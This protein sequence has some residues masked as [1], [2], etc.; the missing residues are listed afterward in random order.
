MGVINKNKSLLGNQLINQINKMLRQRINAQ[1]CWYIRYA[2][3]YISIFKKRYITFRYTTCQRNKG[4]NIY[5][6]YTFI[7]L[8]VMVVYSG[9]L[10]FL[11]TDTYLTRWRNR[12]KILRKEIVNTLFLQCLLSFNFVNFVVLITRRRGNIFILSDIKI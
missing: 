3:D 2:I 9:A 7:F 12:V 10:L 11:K 4:I 5:R 8:C 6:K 1:K